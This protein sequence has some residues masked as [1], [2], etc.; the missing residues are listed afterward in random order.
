[1]DEGKAKLSGD[2]RDDRPEDPDRAEREMGLPFEENPPTTLRKVYH[3]TP[4]A[5]PIRP[6][7]E[8]AR[9]RRRDPDSQPRMQYD[10]VPLRKD[11]S[12]ADRR[13]QEDE[14]D[15]LPLR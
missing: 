10:F 14:G 13:L 7:D 6:A 2:R 3:D 5:E 12:E 4:V 15:N 11:V 1:V 9:P 8:D